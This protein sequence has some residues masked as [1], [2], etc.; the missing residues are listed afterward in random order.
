MC[1]IKYI[2][3]YLTDLIRLIYRAVGPL[4]R[5]D[6]FIFPEVVTHCPEDIRQTPERLSW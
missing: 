6:G 1:D 5:T 4:P 3:H 2:H